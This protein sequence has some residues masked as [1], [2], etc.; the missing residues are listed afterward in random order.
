MIRKI[1]FETKLVLHCSMTY[2]SCRSVRPQLYRFS[3]RSLVSV[4]ITAGVTPDENLFH[5]RF[6]SSRD[7]RPASLYNNIIHSL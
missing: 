1:N 6:N 7:C 2:P 3:T 5:P 4:L